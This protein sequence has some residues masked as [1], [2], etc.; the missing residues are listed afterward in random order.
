MDWE[1]R[2]QA[3]F[4]CGIFALAQIFLGLGVTCFV[5]FR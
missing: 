2:F 1:I 4:F 3:A 5:S